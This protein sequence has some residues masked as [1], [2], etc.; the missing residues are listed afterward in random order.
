M[1]ISNKVL[2]I[3]MLIELWRRMNENDENFNRV[4]GNI[5]KYQI[6]V[7]E[8]KNTIE[9]KNTLGGFNSTLD[10]AEGRISHLKDF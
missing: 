4:M 2:V 8:L 3:K 9:L 7:T 10:E 5:R 6:E 1:E